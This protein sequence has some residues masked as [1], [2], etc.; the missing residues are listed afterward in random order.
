M[1]RT[2]PVLFR[3]K[4]RWVGDGA[5]AS[6]GVLRSLWNPGLGLVGFVHAP[7]EA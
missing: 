4:P 7:N 2:S 6:Q 5:V 1:G 3:P